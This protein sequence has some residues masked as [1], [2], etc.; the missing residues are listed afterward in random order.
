VKDKSVVPILYEGRHVPQ[1]VDKEQIDRW[2]DRITHPLTKEQA[3]DLKKKFSSTG[4]LD[5][6]EQQVATIAWDIAAHF[7]N[8]WKGTGFK[9]QLVARNKAVALLYKKHLDESGLVKSD[10]L[11]SPPDDRESDTDI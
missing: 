11:I 10:V 3:T 2:F 9:G 6:A 7:T 5:Q 1:I 4:Q 8:A